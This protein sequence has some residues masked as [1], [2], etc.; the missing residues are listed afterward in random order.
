MNTPK[1]SKTPRTDDACEWARPAGN[2]SAPPNE[3]YVSTDFARQLETELTSVAQERDR[4]QSLIDADPHSQ[5]SVYNRAIVLAN[6][7]RAELAA[8]TQEAEGAKQK[9]KHLRECMG[10]VG[11]GSEQ[12]VKL[13]Q[14]DA[15]RDYFVVCGSGRNPRSYFGASLEEAL[16]NAFEAKKQT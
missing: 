14:D 11:N 3:S 4:L 12:T 15:T 9:W 2:D 7:L 13:F 6:K 1:Q 16:A 8:A 5:L 10:Y